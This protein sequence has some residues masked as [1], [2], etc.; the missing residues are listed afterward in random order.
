[1]LCYVYAI[2]YVRSAE[3]WNVA[4]ELGQVDQTGVDEGLDLSALFSAQ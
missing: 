3:L 2:I 1:M 4:L